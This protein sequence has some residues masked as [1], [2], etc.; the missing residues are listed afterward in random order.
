MLRH[1][2]KYTQTD[3]LVGAPYE[4]EGTGAVYLFTSD[5]YGINTR[6]SQRITPSEI[7]STMSIRGF[8]MSISRAYDID[9]NNYLGNTK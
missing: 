2:S 7:S 8:G 1:N 5:A 4:T 6:Y 3:L 9:E